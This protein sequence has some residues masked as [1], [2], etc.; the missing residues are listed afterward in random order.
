MDALRREFLHDAARASLLLLSAPWAL[1][2]QGDTKRPALLA[3]AA[4][5]LRAEGKP[6]LVLRLLEDE[7]DRDLAVATLSSLLDETPDVSTLELLAE[8]LLLCM[9]SAEIER[10]IVGS[11]KD[12]T[13]VL[14]DS[15]LRRVEGR[16]VSSAAW[17]RPPLLVALL[18]DLVD[19]SNGDRLAA[20][21]A[22][23]RLH[24]TQDALQ[25]MEACAQGTIAP[26][27]FAHAHLPALTAVVIRERALR[28]SDGPSSERLAEALAC[29]FA[30]NLESQP[31]PRLPYGLRVVEPSRVGSCADIGFDCGLA[32]FRFPAT[33]RF[34]GM[35]GSEP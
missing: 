24:A 6:G 20:R 34:V 2:C 31:G 15:D 10:W 4:V 17:A 30:S 28:A 33:R 21:A 27:E 8:A 13:A 16:S 26:D 32:S 29:S 5:R 9:T 18:R 14:V 23:A 12:E 3:A 11:R 7:G 1:R 19:G 25:S 22:D 35:L